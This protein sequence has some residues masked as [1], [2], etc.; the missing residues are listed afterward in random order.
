[1]TT[2]RPEKLKKE[3][4]LLQIYSLATGATL[5]SGFFLLPGIAAAQAGPAVSI[6]YFIAALLMIPGVLSIAELSTAMPRAG[7]IY[8]FLDRSLGPMFGTIGGLGTWLALV[9]KTAFAL[10]GMG[11][12]ISLFIN[13]LPIFEIACGLAIIFGVVNYFG[14]KKS[15]GFQVVL[16][17]GLLIF[18]SGFLIYGFTGIH[19]ENFSGYWDHGFKSIFETTGLVYISYAGLTK[20]ASVSEEVEDPEKNLPRGMLLALVTTIVFYLIGTSVMVGVL[21]PD[22]LHH[23]LT[24]VATTAHALLG[25]SGAL[26]LTIAAILAFFSVANAAILS[27]SRYPL[28]MSRDRLMPEFLMK[29]SRY[30]TPGFGILLTVAV[31]IICLI[32]FNPIKIAKLASAF[33]L[34]LFAMA[35]LSVIIMRESRIES[36]DPGFR[37]PFY[38]WIQLIGIITPIFLIVEMGLLASVFTAGLVGIGI[39]WYYYYARKRVVRDGAIYHIFARLGEHRFQGLDRELRGILKEKGLREKDP[40]EVII[41]RAAVIDRNDEL[42]FEKVVQMA[43]EELHK[44]IDASESVESLV[45]MF[46]NG[47]RVGAT[48]VSNGVALPHV[49]CKGIDRQEMVIVRVK[50]RVHINVE[51]DGLY[52][53]INEEVFAFFFLVSPDDDP[54]LHLRLLAEIA[55]RVENENFNN[56]WFAAKDEQE[57][58]EIF[59]HD[60]RFVS[61]YLKEGH[62]SG[63]MIGKE[64]WELSLPQGSLITII[65]RR[66]QILIPRGRTRLQEHDRLTIIGEPKGIQQLKDEYMDTIISTKDE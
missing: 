6:S 33:Q 3:L 1:M 31:I 5:S 60:D 15:G 9:L 11:A 48:P 28:A 17:M 16:V 42:T 20:I 26:L 64:I 54:G 4:S 29:L 10:V 65:F 12:Y 24:P 30:G 18:L 27:S 66:G 50:K 56:L 14:T 21:P 46:M 40:F 22:K 32:V 45:E 47:T 62:K 25:E 61:L 57:L 13:D 35:C 36:Y 37:S 43:A 38:P 7:G 19:L 44:R 53:D 55:S 49:R 2:S 23:D 63:G 59:H 41:A 51:N 34:L 52:G 8:Y 39:V 58:K